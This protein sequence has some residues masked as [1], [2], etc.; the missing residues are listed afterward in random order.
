M[1]MPPLEAGELLA[2]GA[3]QGFQRVALLR[4]GDLPRALRAH[5]QLSPL[6]EG[7]FLLAALSCHREEP[8]DLSVP[9]DPHVLLSPFARRNYYGE[10]V[11]RLKALVRGLAACRDLPRRRS[12]V[13]CNS[14]LP[15]KALA[16]AAGLGVYGKNTLIL[17]P[18]LGSR[19]VI[20]GAFLPV[21]LH[22]GEEAPP[23]MAP[24]AFPLCG[25]C[26]ACQDACPTGALQ[27]PGRLER[28]RCLQALST[29]VEPFDEA[30]RRVW[31]F[32]LYGCESC[33]KVCPHN[34][35]LPGETTV[36][37]GALGPSLSIQRLLALTAEQ[38]KRELADTPMGLGW[39]DP[40]A[41]LRNA[42][43]A[44]GNRGDEAL[45]PVLAT[46]RDHGDPLLR[47]AAAWAERR[48]EGAG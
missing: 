28:S 30:G 10:A 1:D 17:V 7:V 27:E 38:L 11:G 26:R 40:R 9:G 34:Q 41:L 48:I 14:P 29:S 42:L 35:Q 21:Q 46:Y 31:G 47:E 23:P 45:L 25:S 5:P 44:A 8:E 24:D 32:R 19:F 13:F 3:G 18:G 39:I 43:L 6:G 36:E 33:Q 16:A 22:G 4:S 37:R 15:E 12:R 2:L 20:A